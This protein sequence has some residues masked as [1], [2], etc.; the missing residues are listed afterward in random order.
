M[1]ARAYLPATRRCS[2]G[3]GAGRACSSAALSATLYFGV[4]A[5]VISTTT[6]TRRSGAA[7]RWN[8]LTRYLVGIFY[9]HPSIAWVRPTTTITSAQQHRAGPVTQPAAVPPASSPGR[10]SRNSDH[11]RRCRRA[12]SPAI[13]SACAGT[14]AGCSCKPCPSNS[15][16]LPSLWRPCGSTEKGARAAD[17]PQQVAL[18]CRA[19]LQLWQHVGCDAGSRWNHSR[20]F[21]G[22]LVNRSCSTRVPYGSPLATG[23]H[24]SERRSST[25][26]RRTT[27]TPSA[28]SRARRDGWRGTY[29]WP[30]VTRR[31]RP[32][33]AK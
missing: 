6:I 5:A 16:S 15:C 25:R 26:R 10:C 12:R 9:G 3:S 29:L 20:N 23:V 8:L 18:L 4:A 21:T 27:S 30:P 2:C 19:V 22:P 33:A 24:W 31:R 13:Y 1:R 14:A 11:Q 17:H 7:A 28:I 32:E